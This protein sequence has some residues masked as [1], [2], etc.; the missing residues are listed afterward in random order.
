M[1]NPSFSFWYHSN[2]AGN[3]VLFGACLAVHCDQHADDGVAV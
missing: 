2:I 3:G 1:S